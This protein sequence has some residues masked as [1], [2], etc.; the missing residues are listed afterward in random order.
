M[1]N[2]IESLDIYFKGFFDTVLS[3]KAL[4]TIAAKLILEFNQYVDMLASSNPHRFHHVYEWNRVGDASSR[5]FQLSAVPTTNGIIISYDFNQSVTPNDN[6]QF[7]PDKAT[8]MESGQ[9]VSF[10]TNQPVPVQDSFRV[11]VFTFVPGGMDTNGAF[12]DTFMTYFIARKL[13]LERTIDAVQ[14][15]TL[16][17]ATGI[18]DGMRVND[19]IIS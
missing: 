18:K 12:Q 1:R 14:S 6:G 15:S 8:V 7:F 11:G 10:E 4:M 17:R 9:Q 3:N 19:S 2:D 16:S 13:T 5:L